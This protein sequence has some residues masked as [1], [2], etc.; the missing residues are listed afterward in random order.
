MEINITTPALLFPA[1]SL[2]L[3]AFTNRFLAISSLIR[4]LHAKYMETGAE[5]IIFQISTLRQRLHLIQVMQIL[6]VT[7][8]FFCVVTMFLLFAG[9][10]W[11]AEITFALSMFLLMGALGFSLWEIRVSVNALN[12][13]ISDMEEE[14]TKRDKPMIRFPK[15]GKHDD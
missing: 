13:E 3:L 12:M 1:I 9:K 4:N 8:F 11:I 6:G 7:S 5:I 15:F 10:V 14:I 2:L